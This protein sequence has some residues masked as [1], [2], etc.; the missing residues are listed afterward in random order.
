MDNSKNFKPAIEV[1]DAESDEDDILARR[2]NQKDK[3]E[4]STNMLE[5]EDNDSVQINRYS[6]CLRTD[7]T[8]I[9]ER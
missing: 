2:S 4:N 1:F 3:I 8:E 6:T 7:V 5:Y 9:Q